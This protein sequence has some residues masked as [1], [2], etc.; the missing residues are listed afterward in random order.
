MFVN[1]M[2][3]IIFIMSGIFDDANSI[4]YNQIN[5]RQNDGK[6]FTT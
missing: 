3:F 1:R 5:W 4:Y 2:S 6:E